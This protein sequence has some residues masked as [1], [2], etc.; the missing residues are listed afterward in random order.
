MTFAGWVQLRRGIIEHL[1][2]GRLSTLEYAVLTVLILLADSKTGSGTINA[3]TLRTFLPELSYDAAK[4][5]LLSLEEKRYIFRQITPFS[6]LAYRYWVNRYV[7]TTG[8][9]KLRQI[10]LSQVF[11]TKNA[12]DIQYARVA[13]DGALDP[14][15]EGALDPAL[16]YKKEHMK[17]ETRE[18][19]PSIGQYKS[20]S[21]CD[22]RDDSQNDTAKRTKGEECA[23]PGALPSVAHVKNTD[24]VPP[25]IIKT[26][27]DPTFTERATGRK[28]TFLEAKQMM[29]EGGFAW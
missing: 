21:L 15:L 17:K 20:D 7:L 27:N 14:A 29:E 25:V 4:R 28:L 22:T 16:H 9:Q 23:L 12:T 10:N 5:I 11:E 1:R 2:D 8:P 18:N 6:K 24:T 19:N 13:P 3:P 26:G